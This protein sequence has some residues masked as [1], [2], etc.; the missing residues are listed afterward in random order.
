MGIAL[1]EQFISSFVL[2]QERLDLYLDAVGGGHPVH[3]SER[4]ALAAGFKGVPLAGVH[5]L[6]AALAA[7]TRRFA[8]VP[9]QLL[10]IQS[11]FLLPVYP[12]DAV[13]ASLSLE[14]GSLTCTE[15]YQAGRY[16][17][18]CTLENG[19]N[20]LELHIGLRFIIPS[21]M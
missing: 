2:G 20:A 4:I 8:D 3:S 16:S 15:R 10:D 11:R 1:P 21:P 7:F 17:G 6:G 19:A 5:V 9:V 18:F 12:G 13:T 14:P